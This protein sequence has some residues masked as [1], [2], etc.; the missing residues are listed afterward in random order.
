MA[1]FK[2]GISTTLPAFDGFVEDGSLAKMVSV[3]LLH[4]CLVRSLREHALFLKNGQDTHRLK[5]EM[6]HQKYQGILVS[7]AYDKIKTINTFQNE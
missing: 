3:Q 4:K 6:N 7:N 5:Q 2:V 1:K